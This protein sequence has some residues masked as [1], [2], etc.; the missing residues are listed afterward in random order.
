[1]RPTNIAKAYI[2]TR[3]F[4]VDL[5]IE[6]GEGGGAENEGHVEEKDDVSLGGFDTI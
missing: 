3:Q 5:V 6:C 1:M 4:T 2:F